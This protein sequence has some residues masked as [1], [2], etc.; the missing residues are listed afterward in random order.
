MSAATVTPAGWS[1]GVYIGLPAAILVLL[2][3]LAI[4]AAGLAGYDADMDARGMVISAGVGIVVFTLAIAGL[5]F[6]PWQPSFHRYY[7]VRG[8]VQDVSKRLISDGNGGM[9]ERYVVRIDGRP[10]GVDDTRASLVHK[11]DTVDLKCKKEYV[12]QSQPG[13]ACN[14]NGP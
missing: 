2:I 5:A 13:W 10:Y 14:W 11:G 7:E 1:L 4:L 9:A 6:W 8:T 3:G 12:W